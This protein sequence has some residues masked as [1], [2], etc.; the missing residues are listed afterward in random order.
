MPCIIYDE[1]AK[2]YKLIEGRGNNLFMKDIK[3]GEKLDIIKEEIEKKIKINL[4]NPLILQ[5]EKGKLRKERLEALGL[6]EDDDDGDI[7]FED[8]NSN[9]NDKKFYKKSK[10]DFEVEGKMKDILENEK[11]ISVNKLYFI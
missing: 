5:Q 8:D 6:D 9:E 2:E 4:P 3:I 1:V 10:Y 11:G 7:F